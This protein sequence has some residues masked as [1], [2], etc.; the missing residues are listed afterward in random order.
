MFCMRELMKLLM[1]KSMIRYFPPKGT[2]GLALLDV[3][4]LNRSP[5]P[6]A[7]TIPSRSSILSPS[8]HGIQTERNNQRSLNWLVESSSTKPEAQD[9]KPQVLNSETKQ[10]MPPPLS[11]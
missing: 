2:A 10:A 3:N 1:T 6:P 7:R 11:P 4:G 9:E 5:A 8:F